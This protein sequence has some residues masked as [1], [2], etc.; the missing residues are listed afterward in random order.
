MNSP[1]QA[2][3]VADRVE[4]LFY[5]RCPPFKRPQHLRPKDMRTGPSVLPTP[6]VEKTAADFEKD[7]PAGST[8][9]A[10]AEKNLEA[11]VERDVQDAAGKKKGGKVYD[12]SLMWTLNKGKVA[13]IAGTRGRQLTNG[14]Y[15]ILLAY[16]ERRP[17]QALW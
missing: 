5:D 17:T 1:R 6:G 11:A 7:M 9:R 10:E 16:L 14:I 3:T 13:V 8:T 15:S 2:R 12:M 4:T